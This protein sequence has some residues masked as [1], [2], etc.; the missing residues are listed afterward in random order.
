MDKNLFLP[1]RGDTN[2][3]LRNFEKNNPGFCMLSL[4]D[5]EKIWIIHDSPVSKIV[6]QLR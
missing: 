2:E 6:L 5:E 4:E 1:Q 3:L